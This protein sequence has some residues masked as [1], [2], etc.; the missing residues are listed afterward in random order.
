MDRTFDV[1]VVGA[2][3]VGLATAMKL[4]SAHPHLRAAV[5]EKENEP[6]L[7]QTG[8]NSGV[9]HSGL[10]YKPGSLKA[11]M[12]VEGAAQLVRF[13]RERGIP[14]EMCGK[15]VVASTPDEIPRLHE[16]YRR[17]TANGLE[18]L[19][20]IGPD[21][22]RDFEPHVR[23]VEAL[24]APTTGIVD[25]REVTRVYADLFLAAGGI[26][27]LNRRVTGIRDDSGPIR[28]ETT[29]GSLVTKAL[30]NCGGLHSDRLARMAGAEPPCRIAPF[31]GE[32]YRIRHERDFLVKGLVYPVPD[33]RFP[34]LGVHFTRMIDGRVEAGPN[35]VPALARE[36]YSWG[37]IS[38][39]DS[40]EILSYEGFRRLALRYWRPGVQEIVRSFSRRRFA[41]AL[42]RLIPE[43]R[44]EDLSPGGAGVRAQALAPDGALIDDFV[45]LNR[46]RMVHVLNAPSPAA[47]SSLAIAEHILGVAAP[48]LSM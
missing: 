19:R 39:R 26:I 16:L 40:K 9:I 34:F 44:E 14:H 23:C 13:C 27:L 22:A 46:G 10:Y 5:V 7:H 1:T 18:G 11:K 31:R 25:F 21:E 32:Y 37:R 47:T 41:A 38:L 12:C 36:G 3:I 29:G 45:I 6:A 24:H 33:P 8:H 35:A 20:L 30:I 48:V 4:L 43:I 15:L 2:G 17:G 28:I 42:Q